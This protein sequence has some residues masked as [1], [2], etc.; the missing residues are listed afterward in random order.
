MTEP[1]RIAVIA[2]AAVVVSGIVGAIAACFSAVY[3][4]RN[5]AAIHEV[6]LSLNSRLDEL[7]AAAHFKGQVEERD[8][9]RAVEIRAANAAK[10]EP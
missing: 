7:I 3:G 1:V 10:L 2:A 8:N 4:K 5:A 9:Q 6:H